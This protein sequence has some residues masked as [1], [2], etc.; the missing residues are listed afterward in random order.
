MIVAPDVIIKSSEL[1]S[2]TRPLASLSSPPTPQVC[3]F[4]VTFHT[5]RVAACYLRAKASFSLSQSLSSFTVSTYIKF[6]L[7]IFVKPKL[8]LIY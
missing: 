7:S 5:S 1:F 8:Q 4:R 6:F 3:L 2:Q